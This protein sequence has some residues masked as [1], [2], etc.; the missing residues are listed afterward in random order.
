MQIKEEKRRVRLYV[1]SLF[2]KKIIYKLKEMYIFR[3][4]ALFDALL[5]Y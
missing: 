4:N 2:L 1:A 3:K 5:K